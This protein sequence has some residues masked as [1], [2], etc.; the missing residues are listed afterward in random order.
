MRYRVRLAIALA[1]SLATAPVAAQT[2]CPRADLPAY[3]H[4]DYENG[5]PLQDALAA[6]YRGVE[7][8]VFLVDGQLRVGHDRGQAARSGTLEALY[9]APLAAIAERCGTLTDSTSG[10]FLLFVEITEQSGPTYDALMAA[11]ARHDRWLTV[12]AR[13]RGRPIEVVLVGW[14]PPPR[15]TGGRLVMRQHRIE[16]RGDTI[17]DARDPRVRLLSLDYGSTMGG[18]WRLP[19][20][21]RGWLETIRAARRGAGG[22]PIRAHDVPA[23]ARTYRA[24]FD[25]GVDLIGTKELR[26]TRA[27]LGTLGIPAPAR[28]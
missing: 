12:D 20:T 5:R 4:N 23:D 6:G 14:L 3:A 9:L 27:A 1:L 19:A 15:G 8:D 28:R 21:R 18:R 10:P 11:L 17:I 2:E 25:A 16:A 22:R 26:A 24:L 13:Q 7:A